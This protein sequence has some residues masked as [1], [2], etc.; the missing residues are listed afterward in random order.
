VNTRTTTTITALESRQYED[1]ELMALEV[2]GTLKTSLGAS[3]LPLPAK[4]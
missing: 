1:A 3:T 2:D 4:K